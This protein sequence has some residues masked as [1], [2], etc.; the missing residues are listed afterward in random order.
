[1]GVD[2][3]MSRRTTER[4]DLGRAPGR[5]NPGD[6][7]S[8]L[9]ASARAGGDCIDAADALRTRGTARVLGFTAKVPST[10]ADRGM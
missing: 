9:V 3:A 4:Q 1:M 8:T 5:A 6:K 10:L 2:S 7:I